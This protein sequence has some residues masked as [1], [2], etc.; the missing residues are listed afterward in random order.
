VIEQ[1]FKHACG[2]IKIPVVR[3]IFIDP[4]SSVGLLASSNTARE[5]IV[6]VRI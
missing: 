6:E 1:F 4:S 2:F 3:G 5:L